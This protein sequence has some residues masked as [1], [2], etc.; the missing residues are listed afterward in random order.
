MADNKSDY[1]GFLN[2]FL[3]NCKT[4]NIQKPL[5]QMI[6]FNGKWFC[7]EKCRFEYFE[8]ITEYKKG[9]ISYE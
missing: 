9:V 3:R 7:S 1:Q 2:A 6:N 5:N 8:S 4:C